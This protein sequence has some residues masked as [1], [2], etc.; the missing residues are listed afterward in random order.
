MDP[1]I[2][3]NEFNAIFEHLYKAI[4]CDHHD[5][6]AA[7]NHIYRGSTDILNN[8]D[9]VFESMIRKYEIIRRGLREQI[10]NRIDNPTT[11]NIVVSKTDTQDLI[12]QLSK[13]I[14]LLKTTPFTTQV[15]DCLV[16]Q[17]H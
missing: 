8:R 6:A 12:N 9:L 5:M 11:N 1:L 4:S 17:Q 16:H 15:W 10:N 2:S 7:I 13:L 3:E 14:R